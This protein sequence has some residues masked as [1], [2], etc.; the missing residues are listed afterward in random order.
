MFICKHTYIDGFIQNSGRIGESVGG[1]DV[2]ISTFQTTLARNVV[3]YTHK[4]GDFN[5]SVI[6]RVH[7]VPLVAFAA[8]GNLT[9]VIGIAI[10][11][12]IGN[13]RE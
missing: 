9:G 11:N 5:T 1:Q 10:L 13:A 8:K 2:F 4:N 7:Q 6:D 12:S 3:F